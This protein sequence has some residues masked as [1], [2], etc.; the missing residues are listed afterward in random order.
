MENG[1]A[2]RVESI[3]QRGGQRARL[4]REAQGLTLREVAARSGLGLGAV[5]EI[6]N[7]KREGRIGSYERLASSLG[8]TLASLLSVGPHARK[9]RRPA[10]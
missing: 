4:L 7:G 2:A 9:V 3:V 8:V 10:A 1:S 5:S 6:E